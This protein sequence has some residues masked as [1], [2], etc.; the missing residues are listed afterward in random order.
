LLMR[1]DQIES[2][3]IPLIVDEAIPLQLTNELTPEVQAIIDDFGSWQIG[4]IGSSAGIQLSFNMI[5][6][7]VIGY[8]TDFGA[9]RVAGINNTTRKAIAHALAEGVL[10]GEGINELS[11]RIRGVFE[12]ASVIRARTIARTEVNSAA[13]FARFDGQRQSGIIHEREW[14]ATMDPRV[15]DIH[16]R[17][18]GKKAK[19]GEP[20]EISGLRA[21][22][23]GNFG[24]AKQ[25]INCRCTTIPITRK[26]RRDEGELLESI[27]GDR[28]TQPAFDLRV[29]RWEEK[30]I[31]ACQRA[32]RRQEVLVL[33]QLVNRDRPPIKV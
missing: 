24:I 16:R 8:L 4:R 11:R 2:N 33:A 15:R 3:D 29:L 10:G 6:P 13:N 25:D 19:M 32:F 22:Y 5:D 9:V 20:F 14:L 7:K 12:E 21:M 28:S 18:H 31:R 1:L 17:L 23:P 26:R 27:D 30:M